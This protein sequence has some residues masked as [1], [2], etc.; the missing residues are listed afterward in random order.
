MPEQRSATDTLGQP[1]EHLKTTERLKVYTP[2]LASLTDH[3]EPLG[4]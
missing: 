1:G 3:N 2:N 4:L